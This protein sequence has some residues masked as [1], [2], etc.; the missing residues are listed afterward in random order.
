MNHAD[1]FF[2]V[3]GVWLGSVPTEADTVGYITVDAEKLEDAR[4]FLVRRYRILGTRASRFDGGVQFKITPRKRL[5][6]RS[7]AC[8]G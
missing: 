8:A 3:P 2:K 7:P 6:K 4:A 5:L 1:L